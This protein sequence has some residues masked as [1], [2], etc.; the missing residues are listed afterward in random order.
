MLQ[1]SC[2]RIISEFKKKGWLKTSGKK[3]GVANER[4]LLDLIEGFQT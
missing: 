4:K 3:I 1:E 2:I